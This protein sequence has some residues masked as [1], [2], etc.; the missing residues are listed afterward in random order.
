MLTILVVV[1]V[2]MLVG[3]DLRGLTAVNGDITLAVAWAWSC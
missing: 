1:L 3:A 2:F